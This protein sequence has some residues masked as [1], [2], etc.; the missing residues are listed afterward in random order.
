MYFLADKSYLA[1]KPETVEGTAVRP[2]VFLPVESFDVKTDMAFAADRRMRGVRFKTNE[3]SEGPR[4]HKGNFKV[5]GD[6]LTLGHV[7]NMTL[8]KGATTG[9]ATDGYTHPFTVDDPKSYTIEAP[10]GPYAQRFFGVRAEELKFV[11]EE[12][13]LK[14]EVT[15]EAMGQFSTAKLAAAV[16]GGSGVT[17]LLDQAYDLLPTRG[18]AVGDVLTL[19]KSDGTSEDVTISALNANGFTITI[20]TAP[21]AS[22]AI[23]DM[24]YLKRQSYTPTS[25]VDPLKF[26]DVLAG[27]GADAASALTASLTRTTATPIHSFMMDFKNNLLKA[28]T[29]NFRDTAV[30]KPQTQECQVE[31]KQLFT[32][33]SQHAAW[34]AKAKQ[35]LVLRILGPLIN[36]A[37]P[38]SYYLKLTFNRVKLMESDEPLTVGSY[39]MDDQKFE[40]CY[41][42]TEGQAMGAELVNLTATY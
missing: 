10:K 42:E 31:V 33:P 21:T 30:I 32:T 35:A 28:P 38:T 19:V 2:T 20:S 8:L 11:F 1:I 24:A 23:G 41:D 15:V 6:P 16:T 14:C 4:S 7:L 27:F 5:W 37:T 22:Y 25:I 40:V 12:A 13:K 3:I 29:T 17:L 36:A 18:L 39:L 34:L 26:G 9:N